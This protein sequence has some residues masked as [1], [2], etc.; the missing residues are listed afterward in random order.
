MQAVEHSTGLRGCF[1]EFALGPVVWTGGCHRIYF[2]GISFYMGTPDLGSRDG[3]QEVL[4]SFAGLCTGAF[5]WD[6]GGV[7]HQIL[8]GIHE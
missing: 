8:K 6:E 5:F 2:S 3:L 1:F 7:F 4:L